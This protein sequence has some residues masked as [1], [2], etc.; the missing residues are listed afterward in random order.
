MLIK[1]YFLLEMSFCL[2]VYLLVLLKLLQKLLS[3]MRLLHF[4]EK[5]LVLFLWFFLKSLEEQ[6]FVPSAFSP[7]AYFNCPTNSICWIAQG[8]HLI[9]FVCTKQLQLVYSDFWTIHNL[10]NILWYHLHVVL[11]LTFL[12]LQIILYQNW[13]VGN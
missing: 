12:F 7:S 5:M 11:L 9:R 6:D 2:V 13:W 8:K 1:S 4:L 10:I 3:F